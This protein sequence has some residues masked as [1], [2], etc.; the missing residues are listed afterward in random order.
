MPHLTLAHKNEIIGYKYKYDGHT[1]RLVILNN[2]TAQF[3][4]KM[5]NVANVTHLPD[6]IGKHVNLLLQVEVFQKMFIVTDVIGAFMNKTGKYLINDLYKVEP[7][8]VLD[9]LHTFKDKSYQ[10]LVDGS[11]VTL[12]FQKLVTIGK[13]Y[14]FL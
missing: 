11:P 10:I 3:S 13:Y 4:D 12:H 9:F 6:N 7:I 14:F 5:H 1:G 8:Q 2:N